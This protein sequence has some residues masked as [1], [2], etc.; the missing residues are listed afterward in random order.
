V[1]AVNQVAIFKDI[2]DTHKLDQNLELTD[3]QY[4]EEHLILRFK[5]NSSAGGI[6]Y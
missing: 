1:T 5:N 6:N 4:K 2:L 3:V